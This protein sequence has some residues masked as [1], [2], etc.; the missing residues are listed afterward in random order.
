MLDKVFC[1]K[2]VK[3]IEVFLIDR[4]FDEMLHKPLGLFRCHMVNSLKNKIR[5][6][7]NVSVEH[8]LVRWI[9]PLILL[10]HFIFQEG[11]RETG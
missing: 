11:L 9:T 1:D 8:Q 5:P 3:G 4:F 6:V 7:C 10:L 2:D